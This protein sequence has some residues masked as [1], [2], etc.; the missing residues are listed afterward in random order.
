MKS[1]HSWHRVTGEARAVAVLLGLVCFAVYLTSLRAG[2]SWDTIPS[3]LLPFS[4][5]REGNLDL[6]EFG[7][8]RSLDPA[9][10]FLRRAPG[11]HWIS[12]YPITTPL[13]G[14]PVALPAVLAARRRITIS[15]W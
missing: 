11:G 6:D 1:W 5:L 15:P 14:V 12:S 7:W 9:P 10:Y 4:I 3:R 13:L 2:P 8:L